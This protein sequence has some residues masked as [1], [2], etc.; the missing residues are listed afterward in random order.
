M[1]RAAEGAGYAVVWMPGLDCQGS[2]F[3]NAW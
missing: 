3:L 1:G 2:V